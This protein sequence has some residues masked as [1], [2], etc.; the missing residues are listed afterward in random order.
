MPYDTDDPTQTRTA[1]LSDT[2]ATIICR[3]DNGAVLK[4]LHGSLRGH[5]NYVRIHD[6]RGLMVYSA[7][8]PVHHE[9]AALPGLAPKAVTSGSRQILL[10]TSYWCYQPGCRSSC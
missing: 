7:D 8:F 5:G 2:A 9:R 10:S 3:M 1:K 4:S 6:N